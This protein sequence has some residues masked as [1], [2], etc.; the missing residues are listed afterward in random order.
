MAFKGWG[1]ITILDRLGKLWIDRFQEIVVTEDLQTRE[2]FGY[3]FDNDDGLLQTVE[4]FGTRQT[5]NVQVTTGSFDKYTIARTFDQ[6]IVQSPSLQLPHAESYIVPANGQIDIASLVLNQQ[7][8]AFLESDTNP[9]QL[10]QSTSAPTAS[11]H[12]VV[13]GQVLIAPVHAGK[14]VILQYLKTYSNLQTIGVESQPLGDLGFLGRQIG[15]RFEI[16]P[17]VYIPSMSKFSGASYGGENSQVTYRAKVKSPFA[18]A[19]IVAFD[20]PVT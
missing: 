15:P 8:G 14:K 11:T 7:V 20:V 10:T 5:Y 17:L 16:G 2:V 18:K 4:A 1:N 12:Q 6:Q 9:L 13:A 19:V 3:P